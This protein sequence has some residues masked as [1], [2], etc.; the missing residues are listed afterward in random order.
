MFYFLTGK[1]EKKNFFLPVNLPVK[2]NYF[3]PKTNLRMASKIVIVVNDNTSYWVTKS[4]RPKYVTKTLSHPTKQ[5]NERQQQNKTVDLVMTASG[6][7]KT[8][9]S[10]A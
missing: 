8:H 7:E 9:E 4:R 6:R 3:F 1:P 2:C 10:Y 5:N